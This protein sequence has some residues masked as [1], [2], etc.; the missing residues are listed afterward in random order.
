MD[1]HKT[2]HVPYDAGFLLVKDQNKH[3]LAF[4]A[5]AH[6]L[7]RS[8]RGAAAGPI[9]P[10]DLGPD[11]SRGFRALKTWLTLKTFGTTEIAAPLKGRLSLPA[12]L[13]KRSKT[14]QSSN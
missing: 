6:Y 10:A 7:R 14:H 12:A 13:P 8:E 9:W 4:A 1:F 3:L 11:L 5:D 2:G